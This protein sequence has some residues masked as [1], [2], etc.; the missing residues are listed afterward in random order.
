[1]YGS[2]QKC[3]LSLIIVFMD[4]EPPLIEIS[5]FHILTVSTR[6]A[7]LLHVTHYQNMNILRKVKHVIFTGRC[8]SLQ[9]PSGLLFL[10]KLCCKC[11]IEDCTWIEMSL[12]ILYVYVCDISNWIL[13]K[14]SSSLFL[15]VWNTSTK[16]VSG[17]SL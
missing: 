14:Q 5:M 2:T 7:I 10:F 6:V 3:W 4:Q 11:Y 1:M 15:P 8:L 13:I 12:L 9:D 16:Y 17:L